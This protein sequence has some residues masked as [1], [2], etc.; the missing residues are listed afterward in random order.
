MNRRQFV[1][2]ISVLGAVPFLIN[3]LPFSVFGKNTILEQLLEKSDNDNILVMIQLHGGNDGLNT[4]VP[5]NQYSNYYNQR[6]NV[7]L[8]YKG[9]RK[10]L[11]LDKSLIDTQQLALHPDMFGIKALYD[12]QSAT[13][14]QNVGYENY[15]MSHF[16]SRDIMFMGG[17]YNDMFESGWIGRF[18]NYENPG[19]PTG[20]PS[21]SKPDPLALELGDTASLAYHRANGITMGLSLASPQSFYDLISGVGINPP[22]SFPDSYY[23]SELEYIMQMELQANSYAERL[24]T[25]Y[26]NG[27][28]ST[29]VDYP[30][31]YPLN[32][33]TQFKKNHLSEQ[34]KILSKL[35]SGGSGTK[36]YIIRIGGFDTHAD[37]VE[38]HDNSLGRHAALL[39]HLSSSVKAF[40]DDLNKSGND[41]KVLTMTFSEFGRRVYSN[42]SYGTDHGKA[43]PVMLFG[44]GLK[45]GVI[46]NN[47]DLND[48]DKGNLKYDIDYRRIFTSILQ[49]W[50]GASSSALNEAYF[51]GFEDQK[52]DLFGTKATSEKDNTNNISK[53]ENC[54]PNPVQNKVTFKFYLANAEN[55]K[56]YIRN[57]AGD[58]INTVVNEKRVKGNHEIITNLTGLNTGI[59][60]YT[61]E[62]GKNKMAK[63][64][65]KM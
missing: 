55:V 48:L 25:V 50:L 36:I 24:K 59:Y 1:K 18:L 40:Y 14:V 33:P 11:E 3:G 23:G 61:F 30:K 8:P 52:L 32:A 35:I 43:A 12:A 16:R 17:G 15:N 62:A 37:Q 57:S 51:D 5:L 27:V 26:D 64:L 29:G 28:N 58:V 9:K 13:V 60:I 53:L 39:Y 31:L 20:Y 41:Q 38:K 34:F 42:A 63:Q 44:P 56:I 65:I 54:Y 45:G 6:A 10:I 46:G 49:D 21:T 22:T 47:P 2:K 7:A 19:Y 4:F